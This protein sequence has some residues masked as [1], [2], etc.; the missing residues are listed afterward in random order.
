[1]NVS[2]C[3]LVTSDDPVVA[4]NQY[5]EG[6]NYQGVTGWACRGL[7]VFWSI[8]PKE[9]IVLF[10]PVIYKMGRSHRGEQVTLLSAGTDAEQL[11]ALQILNAHHNVYFAGGDAVRQCLAIGPRRPKTRHA[12]VETDEVPNAEGGT[13]SLVH[14]FSP[15]L[16][17]RLTVSAISLRKKGKAVPLHERSAIH[18]EVVEQLPEV[19]RR[20]GTTP[21]GPYRAKRTI[22]K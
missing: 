3:D 4:H 10:D 18:R 2:G 15:L 21:A 22:R 5:C 8:S 20:Y 6:I 12:F 17:I 1:V 13:S 7:Q 11:N 14:T 16:P 19:P 9:L